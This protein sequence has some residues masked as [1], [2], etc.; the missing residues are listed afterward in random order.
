MLSCIVSKMEDQCW[1]ADFVGQVISVKQSK[2][3]FPASKWKAGLVVSICNPRTEK[4][5]NLDET[6]RCDTLS[7]K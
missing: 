7:Q 5:D 3:R 4:A 2:F 6:V 1:R